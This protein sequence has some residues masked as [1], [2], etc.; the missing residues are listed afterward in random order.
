MLNGS[1]APLILLISHLSHLFYLFCSV[2]MLLTYNNF[3]FATCVALAYAHPPISYRSPY[4][5]QVAG[6]DAAP[7]IFLGRFISTP[8]P[9]QLLIQQGAVLV[10]SGDGR[11]FINAVAWNVSDPETAVTALGAASG[12][13]IITSDDHGFFFPGFIGMISIEADN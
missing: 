4:N 6:I 1:T 7:Q 13:T 12:T 5:G 8:A 10:S 9:D 11:G 3:I 2:T